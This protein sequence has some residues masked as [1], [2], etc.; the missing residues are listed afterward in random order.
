VDKNISTPIDVGTFY[1]KIAGGGLSTYA[2]TTTGVLRAWGTNNIG[3]LGDGT[4][5]ARLSPVTIDTGVSYSSVAGMYAS[6]CGLTT[7]GQ[8]KCW[9][10][11]SLGSVGETLPEY[12][13]LIFELKKIRMN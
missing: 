5:T 13:K 7:L 12:E 3:Q 6:A 10:L 11:N 8:V 1:S 2:I 4:T 9:G